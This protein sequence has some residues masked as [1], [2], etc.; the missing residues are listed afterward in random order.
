MLVMFFSYTRLINRILYTTYIRSNIDIFREDIIL[1][2][3]DDT[4]SKRILDNVVAHEVAHQWFG[5]LVTPKWW[6]EVWLK[7]GFASF[8]GFLALKMVK[9][10]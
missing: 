9:W 7:E 5:N 2:K 4:E 1:V 8:F 3:K 10:I 6:D